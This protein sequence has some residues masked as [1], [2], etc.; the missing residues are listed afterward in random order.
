LIQVTE[1][2][3]RVAAAL[4]VDVGIRALLYMLNLSVS[5]NKPPA[6][7][8]PSDARVAEDAQLEHILHKNTRISTSQLFSTG[9]NKRLCTE[10][11]LQLC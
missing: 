10:A 7:L 3:H 1:G 6:Q 5:H 11:N 9:Y 8:T 4:V 2:A